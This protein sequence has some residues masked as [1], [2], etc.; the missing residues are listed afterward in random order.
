MTF[1]PQDI[2]HPWHILGLEGSQ[3]V[4]QAGE[5]QASA[6]PGPPVTLLQHLLWEF[7]L[8]CYKCRRGEGGN[9]LGEGGQHR[10][11]C[12]FVTSPK[13]G[14]WPHLLVVAFR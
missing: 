1:D 4:A 12:C 10:Q 14:D 11:F 2:T 8:L 6:L 3:V 13:G 7:V 5:G 9:G